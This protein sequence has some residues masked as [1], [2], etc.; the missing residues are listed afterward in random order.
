[1]D[2]YGLGFHACEDMGQPCCQGYL[3]S[4]IKSLWGHWEDMGPELF[5]EVL[6]AELKEEAHGS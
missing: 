1:M 5:M 4:E 3:V 2:E 6:L